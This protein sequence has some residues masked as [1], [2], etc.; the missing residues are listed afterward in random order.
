M[1]IYSHPFSGS[2]FKVS[3]VANEL[4]LKP[5]FITIDFGKGEHKS[6]WFLE[7]NP[8]GKAPALVDGDLKLWESNAIIIYLSSKAPAPGLIPADPAGAAEVHKWLH[9]NSYNFYH[10]TFKLAWQTYYQPIFKHP[11]DEKALAEGMEATIRDLTLLEGALKGREYLAGKLSLADFSLASNLLAH[12]AM[13]IDF[14]PFPNVKGWLDRM[15]SRDSFKK[16][17][18]PK[19]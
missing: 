10:N 7:I 2:G 19:M 11:K 13:G 4:G 18:P 16:I 3:A 14:K 12:E 5:E 17:W 9:W 1:K 8:N 6:P 15:M